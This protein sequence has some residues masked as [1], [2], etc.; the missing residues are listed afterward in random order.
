MIVTLLGMVK[1]LHIV[2]W[3]MQ[4]M[5]R[6]ISLPLLFILFVAACQ[7]VPSDD[8]VP[9]VADI[10]LLPTSIFLTENAPP[11]GFG[12]VTFDPIDSRLAD[13]TGWHYTIIGQFDGIYDDNGAPASGQF[14]ADVWANELGQARRVVLQINGAAFSPDDNQRVLEGVRFVD[15]YYF[16]DTNGVCTTEGETIR[17]IADLSA[18]QLVGGVTAAQPTGHRQ[19]F[20]GGVQAWQY[21]FAA[22]NARLPA[23][24]RDVSST[25]SLAADLWIAPDPNAVV[26]YELQATVARVRLLFSE[27]TVSGTLRLQYDLDL[28]SVNTL[29]NI[30]VPH[31]C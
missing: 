2:G 8:P 26:R 31:G 5:M 28:A 14:T 30:S 25:V 27:R 13:H 20:E 29:P 1:N 21:T 23:I 18:G 24:H 19:E 10:A 15:D 17:S 6:T 7:P 4:N 11:P 16:V 9:T 12:T 22:E 3:C